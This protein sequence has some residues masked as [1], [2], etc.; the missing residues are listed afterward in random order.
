[1]RAD[2]FYTVIIDGKGAEEAVQLRIVEIEHAIRDAK[3]DYDREKFQERLVMLSNG[4][5]LIYLGGSLGTIPSESKQAA[6]DMLNA[7]DAIVTEGVVPGG[8]VAYLRAAE[9]LERLQA[10]GEER[11][12]VEV[13]RNALEEP[14]RLIA[15]KRRVRRR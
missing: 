4:I 9:A 11:P 1:V 10:S 7:V 14:C 12:G 6:E 8:G 13:A 5:V 2:R 15:V 3:S